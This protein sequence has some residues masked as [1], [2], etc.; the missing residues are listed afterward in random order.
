MNLENLFQIAQPLAF[1]G[2]GFLLLA[3]LLPRLA[4]RIGGFGIPIALAVTHL[5]LLTIHAHEL[6]GGIGSLSEAMALFN[7]PG[8]A[9]AG[10]VHY[11]ALD[12]FI[13]GWEVRTA[14]RESIPHALVVPCLLLTMLAGPTGLL[15]F[16]ALLAWFRRSRNEPAPG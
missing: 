1:V 12:L 2:W 4:D 5:V 11:L 9:M 13:G 10:W 8:L 6:D 16:L 14:R 3:P 7:V 15:V